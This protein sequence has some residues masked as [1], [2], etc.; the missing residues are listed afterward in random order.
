MEINTHENLK[1]NKQTSNT[2]VIQK[3]QQIKQK[4]YKTKK[5]IKTRKHENPK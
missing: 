3:K 4:L 1:Q 5:H 2:T